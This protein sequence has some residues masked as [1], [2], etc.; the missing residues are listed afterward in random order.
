MDGATVGANLRRIRA[1][2]RLTQQ[3][4]AEKA[5]L[6]LPGYRNLERGAVAVPRSDTMLALAGGLSVRMQDLLRPVAPLTRVRFRSS[7]TLRARS[8]VI[9]QVAQ[10]LENYTFVEELLND[11]QEY[12]FRNLRVSGS[13]RARAINAAAAARKALD[14]KD[15]NAPIR[16]ISGLLEDRAGIKLLTL[17]VAANVEEDQVDPGFF[18][19]SVGPHDGGPAIVVNTW[20]RI[21]VE[22]WI[23][24]A[25][26]ELAHL[27]LH[28]SAYDVEETAADKMEET[29]ANAFAAHFLM[30]QVTF[31]QEWDEASGL[32]FVDRV[33]KV[34]RIFRVSYATVLYRLGEL[35]P[36]HSGQLWARFRFDYQRQYGQRL[37]KAD[38][39]GRLPPEEF[40][41]DIQEGYPVALRSH[42]LERLR[43]FD[44][45][46]DRLARLVRRAIDQEKV[47]L[48]RGAEILGVDLRVLRQWAA[49]WKELPA[50]VGA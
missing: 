9:A 31:R 8:H 45:R 18:G 38:E 1:A 39:P 6:S 28:H 36:Q 26:H 44:F 35:Y 34:K 17:Q 37:G 48:S 19:L 4:A 50:E 21:S 7:K 22:R 5:G 27:L 41:S 13:G 49:S 40:G 14:L 29:E 46:Q 10:W 43:P 16:D 25:A 12:R 33:L 23:F 2:K 24:T 47:S 42:E 20:E 3:E 32:S 15:V 11:R 30:P